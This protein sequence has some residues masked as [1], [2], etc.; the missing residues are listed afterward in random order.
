MPT[1][2]PI[3][4]FPA[5]I[6]GENSDGPAGFSALGSRVEREM[7]TF[8]GQTQAE[9]EIEQGMGFL[10]T[11]VLVFTSDH[12]VSVIGWADITAEIV[13]KS[14]AGAGVNVGGSWRIV[15]NGA[16]LATGRW[17]NYGGTGLIR[18][19]MNASI[20]LA[21]ATTNLTVRIEIGADNLSDS[22]Y[23]EFTR[24]QVRRYGAPAT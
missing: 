5:P 9:R 8:R 15:G 22:A 2:T 3:Y 24:V 23:T 1:T 10:P 17:H 16:V 11:W 7:T 4:K 14:G 21:A 20:A 19:S 13:V 12:A 6:A 18:T